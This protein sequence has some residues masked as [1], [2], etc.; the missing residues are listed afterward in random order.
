MH[1]RAHHPHPHSGDRKIRIMR[2]LVA[3]LSVLL[4]TGGLSMFDSV[5]LATGQAP[6]QQATMQE[7]VAADP[8]PKAP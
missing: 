5:E 3:G 8:A 6:E 4:L 7:Q 1:I 2:A